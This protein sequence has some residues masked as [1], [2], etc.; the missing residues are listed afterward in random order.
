M[1][2]LSVSSNLSGI[3]P[4][5]EIKC[6]TATDECKATSASCGATNQTNTGGVESIIQGGL[7]TTLTANNSSQT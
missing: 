4:N 3:L 7:Q 5:V 6:G 1:R 2:F